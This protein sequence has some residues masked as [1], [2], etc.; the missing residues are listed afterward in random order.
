MDMS[1]LHWNDDY[2]VAWIRTADPRIIAVIEQ[3]VDA[4]APRHC[5]M[6][7]VIQHDIAWWHVDVQ[8]SCRCSSCSKSTETAE[9]FVQALHHFADNYGYNYAAKLAMRYVRIFYGVVG[10]TEISPDYYTGEYLTILHMA[11]DNGAADTDVKEWQHYLNNEVY[12][13]GAL[14]NPEWVGPVDDSVIDDA[15]DSHDYYIDCWG[16]YGLDY[17]ATEAIS[18]V[19]A[20][21]HAGWQ[22]LLLPGH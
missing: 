14:V 17:A 6:G 13:V 10:D 21:L 8:N 18:G 16:F 9:A 7:P 11:D 22:E 20:K 1:D 2:T 19:H 15:I 5:G 4:P 12:G 3:D